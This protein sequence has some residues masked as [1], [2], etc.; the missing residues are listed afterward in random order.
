M[1]NWKK[2]ITSGSAATLNSL[3]ITGS[4]GIGVKSPAYSLDVSGSA[5]IVLNNPI[6]GFPGNKFAVANGMLR[7]GGDIE[8]TYGWRYIQFTDTADTY[9]YFSLNSDQSGNPAF[10]MAS[11]G[12]FSINAGSANFGLGTKLLT[13]L[14]NG[15]VGIGNRNPQTRLHVGDGGGGM[16]F[17]YEESIIE[18]NGDTKFGVYT[19]VNDFG[20]GGAAIVLGATNVRD[21]NGYYPGFEFQF[22]PAYASTNNYIRYNFIERDATGVVVSSNTDLFDIY[23]DG[24]A[25][26][27]ALVGTGTQMV[28]ANNNGFISRQAIPE[29]RPYKVYTALLTQSGGDDFQSINSGD[30]TIGV[31]YKINVVDNDG[32]FANVGAPNNNVGTYFVA[33]GTTPNTWGTIGDLKYNNGAPTVTVLENTIGNIWFTY[34]GVGVYGINN[35]G[36]FDYNKTLILN[37]AAEE[38]LS[39][40]NRLIDTDGNGS[41]ETGYWIYYSDNTAIKIKS[42]IAGEFAD[43]VLNKIFLEIRVYN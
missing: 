34:I 40:F 29:A 17:P 30:L 41:T 22:S 11:A 26:F 24:R 14:N 21:D 37:G 9:E 6:G 19:S 1:P 23:A 7:M 33:T 31:T 39:I 32:D 13:V 42:K 12:S 8:P 2:L 4:V 10:S 15:N 35:V 3:Y 38:G 36:L 43:S 28:V 16:G 25:S 18:K 27:K 20:L 5:N